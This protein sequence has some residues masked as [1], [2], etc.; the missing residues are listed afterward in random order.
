MTKTT[1]YRRL[2]ELLQSLGFVSQ[3]TPRKGEYFTDPS[4]RP[5]LVF[6]AYR[7]NQLV[8]PRHLILTRRQLDENGYMERADFE[9]FLDQR[10]T[11]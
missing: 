2:K 8:R 6:P 5:L 7:P 4:G 3:R 9:R 1:T 10:E 11:A